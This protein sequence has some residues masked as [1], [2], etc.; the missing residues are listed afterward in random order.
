[1]GSDH[2]E[3]TTPDNR[4]AIITGSGS[5]IGEATVRRLAAPGMAFVIHALHN[6]E[7]CEKVAQAAQA[8]GARATVVLGDLADPQTAQRLVDAAIGNFG[9]LD[10]LVA[11]AGF[12]VREPFGELTRARLDEVY[13]AVT[14]GFFELVT[15]ALPHLERSPAA[16]V[17]SISTHNVHVF[18]SDYAFFPASAAAKSALEALTRSLA[19]QLAPQGVTANCV[20][21]GLIAKFHGEQFI[22]AQEWAE[23]AAKIPMGRIGQPQE[24]AAMVAF[25]TSAE[26]SYVT[27]Q[28]IH[29]NGGFI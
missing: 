7:G 16:R 14:G 25:L 11:N 8:C 22:S 12:P 15:R 21:P 24:V 18:R 1:M 10:I 13:A 29:V 27:G 3:H 19:L 9:Q 23:F 2:H 6:R 5:G 4:V 28:V 17:V 20:V 26:A